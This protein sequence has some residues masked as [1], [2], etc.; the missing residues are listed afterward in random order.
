MSDPL[1]ALDG[2]VAAS[3]YAVPA[4]FG[5]PLVE[6][7]ALEVGN[8]VVSLSHNGIVTVSGQD[9]LSWLDSMTSQRLIGLAPGQA[10]ETLLLDANGRIEHAIRV[11]D[12]GE[13]AWL[14]V[15]AGSAD[16]LSAYL[17]RMRFALRVEVADVSDE[18]AAVLAFEGGSALPALRGLGL[19]VVEW[20]DPW[21]EIVAGG[22][23]YSHVEPAQH[24]GAGW[25]ATQLVFNRS[26]LPAI[27]SIVSTSATGAEVVRA[28]GLTAL[29]ALEV[30][31]W[32]PTQH[33][34]VDERAIPHE[35]D[36]LRSAVHL[37]KGCYRGQETVAKVHNL[38]HPPRRLAMLHLDGSGGELPGAGALIYLAGTGQVEGTRPIGRVTRSA[39]HHE[40]GGI[41]LALL[42]RSVAEDAE[43]EVKLG[44]AIDESGV[45]VEAGE[46]TV[47]EF[48][49]ANQ[50]PIVP[51]D[52][53]RTRDIPRLQRF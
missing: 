13:R 46:E 9:R 40:W 52:A 39:L 14:L 47:V 51:S 23:Q 8:A 17:T 11:V 25:S 7:R 45:P 36:W 32:R 20:R 1:L 15:D 5:S 43:L 37:T 19:S 21:A 28:A 22:I 4:H 31:A 27:A 38:G 35:F 42:K 53:G 49:A 6:Q 12:D 30:R 29:D 33:G 10:A 41:A 16:E 3:P 34:E 48:V 2:A 50:E 18:Y 26:D 44:G 24:G